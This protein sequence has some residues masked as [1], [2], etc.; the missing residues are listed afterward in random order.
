MMANIG[1]DVNAMPKIIPFYGADDLR[2]FEI[3]RRCM[4][5]DGLVIRRLDELL[6]NGLVLDV[7]AG[8]G[9]TAERLTGPGRTIIP[10]EP[11]AGMIRNDRRMPWVRGAAQDLPFGD[12]AFAGAYAT[13]AYFFPSI[14]HG[15]AGLAAVNR[16]VRPSGP[17]LIADNAGGDEFSAVG[18]DPI[19]GASDAAWWESRGFTRDVVPTT[20][21]FDDLAEAQTLLGFYFGESGKANAR[22]EIGYNVA[23]YRTSAGDAGSELVRRL[24]EPAHA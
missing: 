6:P 22:I 24:D 20:F 17:I 13:W 10:L 5:R 11:A 14:G 19:E 18:D 1:K 3:E 7:G 4:D 21:R 16:A 12:N 9:F 23:I 15:D 8:D 2:M